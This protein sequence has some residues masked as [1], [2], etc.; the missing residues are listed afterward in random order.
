MF[1]SFNTGDHGDGSRGREYTIK[2]SLLEKQTENTVIQSRPT[3][4]HT[5]T[6]LM[7]RSAEA[8]LSPVLDSR[9][10]FV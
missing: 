7:K 5:C 9:N 8:T 1:F 3:C 10:E 6:M 4:R 2:S